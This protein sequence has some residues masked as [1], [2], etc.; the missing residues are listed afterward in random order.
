MSKS[1]SIDESP[2]TKRVKVKA[3]QRREQILALQLAGKTQ[4]QIADVLG[5]DRSTIARDVKALQPSAALIDDILGKAQTKLREIMPVEKRIEEYVNTFNMAKET[6]QPSAGAAI[7]T[8]L[9]HIDGMETLHEQSRS[10]THE[11]AQSQPMFMLPP[12]ASV[13][14]TVTTTSSNKDALTERIEN[15]IDV[16]PKESA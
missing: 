9:D 2:A 16:T 8:R 7:L 10:K 6:K 13:N 12:G 3:S 11:P 5:V 14:V 4:H 15:A 1:S